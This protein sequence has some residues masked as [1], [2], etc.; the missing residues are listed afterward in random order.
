MFRPSSGVWY[1][2]QSSTSSLVTVVL[3]ARIDRPGDGRLR[4]RMASPTSRIP[5]VHRH[6]DH[7]ALVYRRGH[8]C[9]VRQPGRHLVPGDIR[10]R[11]QSRHRRLST[12]NRILGNLAVDNPDAPGVAPAALFHLAGSVPVIGDYDGDSQTDLTRSLLVCCGMC[13]SALVGVLH[14][15]WGAPVR[16][17]LPRH[18]RLWATDFAAWMSLLR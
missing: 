15:S 18:P 7:P 16:Y 17:C 10:W 9:N 8:H 6:V 4:W 12:A 13:G 11:R 1:I 14:L 5:S 2:W 3:G